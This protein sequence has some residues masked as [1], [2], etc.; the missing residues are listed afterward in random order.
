MA[1]IVERVNTLSIRLKKNIGS[2]IYISK[3]GLD[4]RHFD[5]EQI[6]EQLQ[7]ASSLV[8]SVLTSM[9][10]ENIPDSQRDIAFLELAQV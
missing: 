2:C 10:D 6:Y 8:S 9:K 4:R 1:A 3:A 5:L 7:F